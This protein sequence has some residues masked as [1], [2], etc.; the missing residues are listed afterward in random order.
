MKNIKSCYKYII[1]FITK[2][3]NSFCVQDKQNLK[4]FLCNLFKIVAK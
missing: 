3:C 2:K 1:A 4:N